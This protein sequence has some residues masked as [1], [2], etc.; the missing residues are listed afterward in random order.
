MTIREEIA[1]VGSANVPGDVRNEA[2]AHAEAEAKL[3]HVERQLAVVQQL[4][5]IGSW[6]WDM[7]TNAVAWSDELY[8]IYGLEP[9]S[10][11]ITF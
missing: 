11:E 10:C 4:T 8:R 5:H 3:R 1:H 7:R 9:Q 2:D 6:E